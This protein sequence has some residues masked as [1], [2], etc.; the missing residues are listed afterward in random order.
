MLVNVLMTLIFGKQTHESIHEFQIKY[1]VRSKQYPSRANHELQV[2]RK[3]L[4]TFRYW[5][6]YE[7][8]VVQRPSKLSA[9]I[10]FHKK[11]EENKIR[12]QVP[13]QVLSKQYLK[14]CEGNEIP[15]HRLSYPEDIM[16]KDLIKPVDKKQSSNRK[17]D[18]SSKRPHKGPVTHNKK[19]KESPSNE[20]EKNN[21][22]VWS[23]SKKKRMRGLKAKQAKREAPASAPSESWQKA[24]QKDSMTEPNKQGQTM[25]TLQKSF[26]DRLSGSRFRV[27]NEE[28]YTQ[29]S[30]EAF[31]KFQ[32]NPELF[33]QYHAGYRKQT[34]QWPTNPVHVIL[35]KIQNHRSQAKPKTPLEIADFGCGDAEIAQRLRDDTKFRVYSFDLVA[36]SELVTACDMS[37]VPLES[38]TVD[39]AVF[40]LSLMGTNLA[41]FVREAFRVLKPTGQLFVAEVRSRFESKESKDDLLEH[42]LQ[43][44]EKLGF[45]CRKTDRKNKMFFLMEF[46]KNGKKPD[47]KL[48]YTAKACIYKRR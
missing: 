6:S 27:L 12:Y 32:A 7:Q 37:K 14:D 22:P 45:T 11:D 41:D 3:V 4:L 33:D 34:E 25:S 17:K 26:Q 39:L 21:E 35:Q 8:T 48:E 44:M 40:C 9:L 36:K 20:Q 31:Q 13:G 38:Q 29:P 15:S 42:F 5:C 19:R 30:W 46:E 24:D 18:D 2:I 23:K 43:V 1:G 47:P 28:L 10:F 16:T